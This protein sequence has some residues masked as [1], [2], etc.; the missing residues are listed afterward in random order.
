MTVRVVSGYN[1]LNGSGSDE[2]VQ[3]NSGLPKGKKDPDESGSAEKKAEKPLTE[4]LLH[5]FYF[6]GGII[7]RAVQT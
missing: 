5:P 3:T 1:K 4:I 6:Y 2:V 7:P